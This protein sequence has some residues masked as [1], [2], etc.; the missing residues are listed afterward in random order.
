LLEQVIKA[1]SNKDILVADFFGESGITAKVAPDLGRK[2]IHT[3]VGLNSIQI[4]RDRLKSQQ[5]HFKGLDIQYGLSLFRNP[6]QTMDKL[7]QLIP[8]L[9]KKHQRVS[10]ILVWQYHQHQ[11]RNYFGL[12][13]QFAQLSRKNG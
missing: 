8:G 9:Q 11:P 3:D 7:T 4:V 10:S 5:A 6:Q 13:A 12:C 1:A 2:V